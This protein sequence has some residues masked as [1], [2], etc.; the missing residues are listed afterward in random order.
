MKKETNKFKFTTSVNLATPVDVIVN[1]QKEVN[2]AHV[3]DL[4]VNIY[5]DATGRFKANP[6]VIITDAHKEAAWHINASHRF[7]V[8]VT[9][10]LLTGHFSYEVKP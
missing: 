5:D 8:E 9:V 10:D 2:R 4:P 1:L 6:D 3:G 7:N